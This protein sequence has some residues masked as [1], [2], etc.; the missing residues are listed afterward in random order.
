MMVF[1]MTWLCIVRFS[2]N[3]LCTFTRNLP[4]W[5]R[6]WCVT[7]RTCCAVLATCR[8]HHHPQPAASQQTSTRVRWA[9]S[10]PHHLTPTRCSGDSHPHISLSKSSTQPPPMSPLLHWRRT[11]HPPW[12]I[13]VLAFLL[14]PLHS[15]PPWRHPIPSLAPAPTPPLRQTNTCP[16]RQPDPH[17]WHHRGS[18]S[19]SLCH[20]RTKWWLLQCPARHRE[21]CQT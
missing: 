4:S 18:P 20:A 14:V 8:T 21:C 12:K 3:Y 16:S 17:P 10:S 6:R 7:T 15:T 11:W 2:T 1:K 9:Q 19:Q 5:K 13:R